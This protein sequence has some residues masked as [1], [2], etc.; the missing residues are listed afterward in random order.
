[1]PY[2]KGSYLKELREAHQRGEHAEDEN[3][4][5][6]PCNFRVVPEGFSSLEEFDDALIEGALELQQ[7]VDEHDDGGH[8]EKPD[9]WCIECAQEAEQ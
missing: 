2:E 6:Q 8:K 9:P 7:H 1:M 4:D 3:P 5:C